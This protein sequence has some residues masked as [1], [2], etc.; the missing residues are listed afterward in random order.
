MIPLSTVYVA[1]LVSSYVYHLFDCDDAHTSICLS[2]SLSLSFSLS[3]LPCP[4]QVSSWND[5]GFAAHAQDN[6]RLFRTGFFPGLGWMLTK[7]LWQELSPIWPLDHWDWWMRTSPIHKGKLSSTDTIDLPS[8]DMI[9]TA[10][11]LSL[12]LSLSCA[13]VCV[14][15]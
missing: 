14:C 15:T 8:R 6:K 2:L 12:S 11:S 10:L 1:L 4:T 3:L 7:E 5:N 9:L 13:C